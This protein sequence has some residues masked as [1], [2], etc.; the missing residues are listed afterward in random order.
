MYIEGIVKNDGSIKEV[1]QL[2][3]DLDG[4]DRV[5][6]LDMIGESC[7]FNGQVSRWGVTLNGEDWQFGFNFAHYFTWDFGFLVT[8]SM[9]PVEIDLA[10]VSL[11]ADYCNNRMED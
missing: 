4:G 5:Y 2:W 6:T 3:Y 8:Y 9:D 11:I 1:D 7:V 10:L